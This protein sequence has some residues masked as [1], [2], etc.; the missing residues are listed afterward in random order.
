MHVYFDLEDTL[1]ES[2]YDLTFLSNKIRFI[3]D[4]LKLAQEK[5]GEI[6]SFNI[7]SF[8][9]INEEDL[10]VFNINIKPDIERIFNI[11]IKDVFIFSEEN[12]F[13]LAKK[14]G[15]MV[16]KNDKISDV[17]L[18]NQKE[19]IF[20]LYAQYNKK[21]CISVLFDDMVGNN[22]KHYYSKSPLQN[23]DNITTTVVTVKVGKC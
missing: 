4:Q 2:W 6:E 12:A 14:S 15:I 7:F 9:I 17:F 21:G 19:E 11:S 20:E 13:E 23:E 8:A 16:L 3:K 18:R 22:V 1:I 10:N 5:Y